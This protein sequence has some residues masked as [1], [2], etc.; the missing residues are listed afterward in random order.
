MVGGV[1]DKHSFLHEERKFAGAGA[2]A[3]DAAAKES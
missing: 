2:S 1:L 3:T